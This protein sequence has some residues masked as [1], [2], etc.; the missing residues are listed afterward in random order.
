MAARTDDVDIARDAALVERFQAGDEAAFDE[1]Y[2]RYYARLHRACRR[3]LGDEFD[4]DEAAQEALVRAY[5]ALPRF[6]G[7]RRFYP[8]LKVIAENVCADMRRRPEVADAPS[9]GGGDPVLDAVVEAADRHEVRQA[10]AQLAPRQQTALSMWAEGWPSSHI[11]AELGCTSGAADVT[12]HRAR[13]SFRRRYLSI[14]DEKALAGA[15]GFG[16]IGRWFKGVRLHVSARVARYA[17]AVTPL[18]ERAMVGVVA[19]TV[20]AGPAVGGAA[21]STQNASSAASTPAVAAPAPAP[22]TANL[23]TPAVAPG[24]GQPVAAGVQHTSTTAPPTPAPAPGVPPRPLGGAVPGLMSAQEA[25]QNSADAPYK[26]EYGPVWVH[27]DPRGI[28]RHTN[29]ELTTKPH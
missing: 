15:G 23:S 6:G 22:A 14:V 9:P 10:L 29:I 21:A 3:R 17:D 19:A 5:R 25:K 13:Q 2:R 24:H 8:W 20:I 18:A 12:V 11:A 16:A 4:A 27:L 26:V 1:L 28:E 7:S